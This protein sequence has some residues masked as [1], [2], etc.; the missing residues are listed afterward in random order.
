[1]PYGNSVL[2]A[3][4]MDAWFHQRVPYV[5]DL[6]LSARQQLLNDNDPRRPKMLDAIAKVISP[7]GEQ[8]GQERTEHAALYNLFGDPTMKLHLPM[9]LEMNLAD[10]TAPEPS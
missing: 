4:L 3:G 2:A 7:T 8:L 5:G 1:M 6:L 9:D 10:K